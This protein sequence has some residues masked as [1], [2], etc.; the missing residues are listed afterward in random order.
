MFC[1]LL[2]SISSFLVLTPLL[3]WVA[4]KFAPVRTLAKVLLA[5]FI[6]WDT[7]RQAKLKGKKKQLIEM[8]KTLFSSM[9][10]VIADVGG[11]VLE[12]GAGSGA[13]LV[14]YPQN[15][16]LV[17]LDLNEHF[18]SYLEGN[19][20]VHKHVTLESYVVGNAEDMKDLID[21]ESCSCVVSSLTLCCADQLKVLNEVQRVLKPGGRFYFIEHIIEEPGTW[22]RWFQLHFKTT[23][24]SMRGNCTLTCDTNK[25]IENFKGLHNLNAY[26]LYRDLAPQYFFCHKTYVGYAD[27]RK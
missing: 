17:T 3:L 19:L 16:S 24:Q 9:E 13:N 12:I 1:C 18:R 27:K 14:Y 10:Q 7:T 23:W 11:N 4:F 2:T 8:S 5:K 26:I 6:A 22:T 25:V 15:T 21:D 20:A